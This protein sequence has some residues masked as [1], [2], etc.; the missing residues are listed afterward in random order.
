[1]ET[2][3]GLL[4]IDEIRKSCINARV[5][6][7]DNVFRDVYDG[8]VVKNNRFL[9]NKSHVI[10]LIAFQDAFEIVNPLGSSKKNSS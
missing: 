5:S 3:K 7:N 1:M 4:S 8:T 2:L 9:S 10:S 6:E